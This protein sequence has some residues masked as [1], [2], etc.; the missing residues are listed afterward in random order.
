MMYNSDDDDVRSKSDVCYFLLTVITVLSFISNGSAYNDNRWNEIARLANVS[1][2]D[3]DKIAGGLDEGPLN[4]GK[5]GIFLFTQYCGPGERVWKSISGPG[6][7]PP[8]AATYADIDVCCKQH[9]ECPNYISSDGDYSRYP[10]LPRK[11][12][13]FSRLI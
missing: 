7:V 4:D 1:Q 11:S 13:I 12:Q 5:I 9:D 2:S 3:F 8:K 6:K 10:G